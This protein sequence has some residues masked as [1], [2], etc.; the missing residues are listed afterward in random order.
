MFVGER[1]P[2]ISSKQRSHDDLRPSVE[3]RTVRAPIE[4]DSRH[5]IE[6]FLHLT[7]TYTR[8]RYHEG[9]DNR[10]ACC[11]GVRGEGKGGG[12][13]EA[14]CLAVFWAVCCACLPPQPFHGLAVI[15]FGHFAHGCN[16]FNSGKI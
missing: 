3:V 6:P 14:A 1:V 12:G 5:E 11:G 2:R 8:K 7:F 10:I 16:L 4:G 15:P 13:G 9:S